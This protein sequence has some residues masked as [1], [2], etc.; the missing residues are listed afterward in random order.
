[1][2]DSSPQ[3]P[4][5]HGNSPAPGRQSS[6]APVC[7]EFHHDV[8]ATIGLQGDSQFAPGLWQKA[9]TILGTVADDA[10]VLRIPAGSPER[11]GM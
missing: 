3:A 6:S 2:F 9:Y 10:V 8:S 11:L 1:M 5:H 4:Y 7:L